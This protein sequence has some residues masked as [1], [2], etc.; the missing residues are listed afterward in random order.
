MSKISFQKKIKELSDL[1]LKKAMGKY[2][3]L[4]NMMDNFIFHQLVIDFFILDG[5]AKNKVNS[6]LVKKDTS[7]KNKLK[8]IH[9]IKKS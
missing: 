1:F 7:Q 6:F 2:L 5:K 3:Y 9:A 4:R 8:V